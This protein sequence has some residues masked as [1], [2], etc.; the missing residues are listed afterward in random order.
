MLNTYRYSYFKNRNVVFL[1]CVL[2]VVSVS[3]AQEVRVIDNKGTINIVRNNKVTTSVTAPTDPLEGDVWFDT[4]TTPTTANIWNETSTSWISL[5]N[6]WS[7]TGNSGTSP[8]DFIGTI[9]AQDFVLKSNDSEKV[10]LY[11]AKEEVLVSSNLHIEP[12]DIDIVPLRISPT[13][14][15]PTGNNPGEFY[16]SL[17]DGLLY[18]FD[19]TRG[20]KWLSVDRNLIGWGK[21]GNTTNEYLRQ[22][23][24]SSSLNN[25][26]RM[27]R[28]GTITAI[29]VQTAGIETYTLQIWKNDGTLVTTFDVSA[30]GRHETDIDIDF[31][32]TD[33]LQCR[34]AGTNI[35]SP[36]V[37]IEIAWRQ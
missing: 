6:D 29:T 13:A 22:F 12:A 21:N 19:T 23:N 31:V 27:I 25:G 26:W 35:N 14:A 37:L 3:K 9:D 15:S 36:Q 7:L 16:V 4:N 11:G 2:A 17:S 1:F 24:G 20:G 33:F 34:I 8:T 30:K 5:G 10:K 18:T 32:E 28:D